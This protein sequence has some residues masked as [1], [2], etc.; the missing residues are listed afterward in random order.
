LSFDWFIIKVARRLKM[1][2]V[3]VGVCDKCG[4]RYSLGYPSNYECDCGGTLYPQDV[5]LSQKEIDELPT[6]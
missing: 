2:K 1:K 6:K 3:E 4:K 5:K